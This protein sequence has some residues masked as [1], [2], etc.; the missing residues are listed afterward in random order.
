MYI[1]TQEINKQF[2]GQR[3]SERLNHILE[4]PVWISKKRY[5]EKLYYP[6]KTSNPGLGSVFY[7]WKIIDGV[8]SKEYY[9]N[10]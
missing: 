1:S 6:P 2:K 9:Q 7:E 4:S 10:H 3:Q 8:V 5:S